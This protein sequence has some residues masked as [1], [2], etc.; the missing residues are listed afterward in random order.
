MVIGDLKYE[1]ECLYLS[2]DDIEDRY[3]VVWPFGTTWDADREVVVLPSGDEIALGVSVSG[4]GGYFGVGV[5][6]SIAG[7]EAANVARACVDNAYG[8][9]AVVNNYDTGIAP[10]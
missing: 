3:P 2:A 8:E 6:E 9:V 10:A 7:P 4:G 5:V 1:D